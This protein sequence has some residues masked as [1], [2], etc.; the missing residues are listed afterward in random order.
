MPIQTLSTA[1]DTLEIDASTRN[2]LTPAFVKKQYRKCALKYHPDKNPSPDAVREFQCI[3]EA[4][5]CLN[6]YLEGI[7]AGAEGDGDDDPFAWEENNGSSAPPH[8][9]DKSSYKSLFMDVVRGLLERNNGKLMFVFSKLAGLC[10]TAALEYLRKIEKPMLAKIYEV[11]KQQNDV[12]RFSD[13]FL[14][15]IGEILKDRENKETT[16]ILNPHLDDLMDDQLYKLTY[17]GQVFIVPLWHNELVYDISGNDLNVRCIPLLPDNIE[18]DEYN[19]LEVALHYSVHEIWEKP[20]VQVNIGNKSVYFLPKQ[21][22]LTSYQSVVLK[23]EGISAIQ[24]KNI[25]DVSHRRDVVLHIH[26]YL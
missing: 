19:N 18:L 9:H 21:L 5:D 2:K 7:G 10:E 17:G 11:A 14:D 24:S 6:D 12:F 20:N 15:S 25:Y 22:R 4:Y 23:G 8:T 13:E 3:Q 26:L 16:I 1:C